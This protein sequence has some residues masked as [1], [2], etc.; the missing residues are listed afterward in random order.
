MVRKKRAAVMI[1]TT[2]Q[3]QFFDA[4]PLGDKRCDGHAHRLSEVFDGI[5]RH[6]CTGTFGSLEVFELSRYR[7][8]PRIE[9]VP[10]IPSRCLNTSAACSE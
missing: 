10:R 3:F 2:N 5:G 8:D 6:N 4:L 7:R 9:D 1:L